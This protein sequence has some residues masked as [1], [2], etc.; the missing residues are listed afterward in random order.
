[1]PNRPKLP[2]PLWESEANE[3]R[4]RTFSWDTGNCAA[5]LIHVKPLPNRQDRALRGQSALEPHA[6]PS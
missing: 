4:L 3:A 2:H 5:F 1:M 6:M